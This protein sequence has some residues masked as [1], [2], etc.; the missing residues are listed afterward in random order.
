MAFISIARRIGD[1]RW[2]SATIRDLERKANSYGFQ[3][4][5]NCGLIDRWYFPT[6]LERGNNQ[7]RY[8]GGLCK[9]AWRPFQNVACLSA[10]VGAHSLSSTI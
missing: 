7:G 6:F 1:P 9:L 2:L 4:R 5:A 8:V 3:R 10:L